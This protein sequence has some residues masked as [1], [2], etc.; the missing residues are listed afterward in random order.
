MVVRS[1]G[2]FL[3]FGIVPCRSNSA[4][5]S[6]MP[7]KKEVASIDA[8]G[9]GRKGGRTGTSSRHSN[10]EKPT[11][12]LSEREFCECFYIPNNI[13]VHLVDGDLTSTKK[14]A[15]D[16]IFFS[17]EQFNVGLRFPLLSIFK[18][19]LHYTQIS[20]TFIHPNIILVLMRC[21]IL[22]MFLH[23]DL[24]ML[25]VFFIYTIKKG[26]KDIFSLF[27]H[28]PSLQLV[29]GLS[30]SNKGG[31][32]GHILVQGPWVGLIEH[33]KMDFRPN[34]SLKIPRRNGFARFFTCL[35]LLN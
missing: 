16:A 7:A 5:C 23:L 10:S 25:E 15:Q 12:L 6:N 13:S 19:F 27:T 18:Q 34:F 20:L 35:L 29:I 22:D 26:K 30:D 33:L 14:E 32:K 4:H 8:A 3:T 9:K 24:S 28:I 11:R 2:C 21:S 17:K 1:G 31:T